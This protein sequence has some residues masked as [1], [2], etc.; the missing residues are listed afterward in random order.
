MFHLRDRFCQRKR[1]LNHGA[2]RSRAQE[3]SKF[4]SRNRNAVHLNLRLVV[5]RRSAANCETENWGGQAAS[6]LF[7]ATGRKVSAKINLFR[8]TYCRRQAAGDCRLAAC[9]PQNLACSEG[10]AI[11]QSVAS[12]SVESVACR[13]VASTTTAGGSFCFLGCIAAVRAASSIGRATGL[14]RIAVAPDASGSTGALQPEIKITRALGS[15]AR[16]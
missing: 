4:T 5:I 1:G 15:F 9:A 2:G 10:A 11:A 6:L 7:S 16:M 13:G 12:G 8:P 3:L 14:A